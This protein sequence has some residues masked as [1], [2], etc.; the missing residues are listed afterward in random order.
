MDIFYW[1]Y[2]FCWSDNLAVIQR[3]GKGEMM[4]LFTSLLVAIVSFVNIIIA[5]FIAENIEP[6][7]PILWVTLA[8]GLNGILIYLIAR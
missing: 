1:R 6:Y 4:L 3:L 8:I 7:D 5:I 2:E